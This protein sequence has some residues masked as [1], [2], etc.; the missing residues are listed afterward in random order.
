MKLR[1]SVNN[2]RP[3]SLPRLPIC[4]RKSV[5][6]ARPT[7]TA[8]APNLEPIAL[9]PRTDRSEAIGNVP[10]IDTE[11][12]MNTEVKTSAQIMED[13]F[14][15]VLS[16]ISESDD[17]DSGGDSFSS[18]SGESTPVNT[19]HG[20]PLL[21]MVKL[22]PAL[23]TPQNSFDGPSSAVLR[24]PRKSRHPRGPRS[25][26][27]PT[28]PKLARRSPV[29]RQRN[30]DISIVQTADSDN[31]RPFESFHL[32]VIVPRIAGASS[33]DPDDI[34]RRECMVL[35]KKRDLIK[36]MISRFEEDGVSASMPEPLSDHDTAAASSSAEK[37][38]G[39]NGTEI[40]GESGSTMHWDI[41]GPSENAASLTSNLV[42]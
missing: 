18:T 2:P 9:V 1:S 11:P 41:Q 16:D 4:R 39:P 22:S 15:G 12:S 35:A 13:I 17:E 10:A 6:R 28:R 29:L 5:A 38:S 27:T 20:S 30:A 14:D 34:F 40:W 19:E 8:I 25:G 42:E 36:D 7:S 32:G 24:A 3:A 26:S 31:A 33:S 23:I 21:N 37:R